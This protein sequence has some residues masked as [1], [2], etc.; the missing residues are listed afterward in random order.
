MRGAGGRH[1]AFV[2]GL[3]LALGIGA[4]PLAAQEPAPQEPVAPPVALPANVVAPG[5]SIAGVDVGGL[6]RAD[7]RRAVLAAHVQPRLRPLVVVHRGVRVGIRPAAAGYRADLDYSLRAAMLFG[8]SRPL[9]EGGVNV[10]LRESVDVRRLGRV[11]QSRVARFDVPPVDAAFSLRGTTPVVRDARPGINLN[12]P[13][14]TAVLRVQ[15]IRRTRNIVPLPATRVRPAVTTLP[16]AIIIDRGNFR[17]TLWRHRAPNQVYPIAVGKSSHP[18]PAGNFRV[19]TKQVN[20]TWFP[21]NSPWAA[22]LGPVPPG[23]GN[24]LGT[25]WIGTSAPAIGIHGTPVPSSIGTRASHGCIRM[26]IRDV[27]RLYTQVSIGTRV[28]IR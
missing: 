14:A 25:R 12:L 11:L 17:L 19:I 24:P 1:V 7:A 22:G 20:P 21:P 10:P 23:P 6:T 9:P 16:A 5:V 15:M 28:Y 8:R 27:E 3:G 2:A 13:R 4:V 26:Y 18:T